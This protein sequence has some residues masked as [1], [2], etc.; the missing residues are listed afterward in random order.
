MKTAKFSVKKYESLE[1]EMYQAIGN[2]SRYMHK[3]GLTK[4]SLIEG[5]TEPEEYAALLVQLMDIGDDEVAKS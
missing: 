5:C 2:L 3:C 1:G 4:Y